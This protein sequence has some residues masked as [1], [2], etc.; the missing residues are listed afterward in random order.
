MSL[1]QELFDKTVTHLLTQ[2][3]QSISDDGNSC[4]YRGTNGLKCAIGALID[5]KWY[6]AERLEDLSIRSQYVQVAVA[7]S[8]G[9]NL[10]DCDWD[11]EGWKILRAVQNIHDTHLP[12]EW[13]DKL[14]TLAE[15]HNLTM[16]HIS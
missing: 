13:K 10:V 14:T 1:I 15:E 9:F 4:A 16:P 6:D 7:K 11:W 12:D 2:M 8:Q 5:D 3:E